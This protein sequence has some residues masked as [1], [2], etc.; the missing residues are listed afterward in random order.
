M[1][2]ICS[3][4]AIHHLVLILTINLCLFQCI[5]SALSSQ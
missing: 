3:I 2:V 4:L 1:E 5:L